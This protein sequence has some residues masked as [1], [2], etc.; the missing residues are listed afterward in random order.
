M[1]KITA[2]SLAAVLCCS[3]VACVCSDSSAESLGTTYITLAGDSIQMDGTGATVDGSTV[4]ITSAGTYSIS[5]TLNDGQIRVD[6]D[7]QEKVSLILN[8]A[9]IHCSSSAPIYVI[10]ADKTVIDLAEGTSNSISDGSSY[11]FTEAESDEPN[12]AIFSKDDLT[13]KGDGSLSV[14]ANYNDGITSK[15]DLKISGGSITVNAVNDGI[16]GKDSVEVKGGYITVTAGDD[17]IQSNNDEDAEKGIVSIEDGTIYIVA[18]GNGIQAETTLSISGGDIS[19][20]SGGGSSGT[21][22]LN[23]RD[24]RGMQTTT[25]TSDTDSAKGLKAGVQLTIT[26][27]TIDIDSSDDAVHSNDGIAI[28]GGD[29][30]LASGDDA[31]HADSALEINGGEIMI[32]R[33]YEGLESAAIT[34]NAGEIHLVASDD[35]VNGVTDGESSDMMMGRPG[36]NNFGASG[37]STLAINGGYLVID[38]GGDGLDI[39]GPITMTGGTVIINGPTNS[40]NGPLDYTGSYSI[41]GGTLIAAGSSGMAMAPSSSSLQCSAMLVYSASQTAG[42]IIHIE[43]ADGD[44]I[45]TF[46]PSK[47]YQSVV[48]SSPELTLGSDYVV[49]SGGSTT[50]TAK[51][52]LYS[53]GT[54]TPGT[55]VTNFE[56]SGTVTTVG[57]SNGQMPGNMPGNMAGNRTDYMPGSTSGGFA[58][59]SASSRLNEFLADSGIMNDYMQ[60]Y[61]TGVMNGNMPGSGAMNNN[62]GYGSDVM[63]SYRP[64]SGRMNNYVPGS[65]SSIGTQGITS[66]MIS[67]SLANVISGNFRR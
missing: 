43:T 14:D 21:T 56:I 44:E 50:G 26:G 55:E 46:K 45:L 10:N 38:A 49:Y 8:G 37:S 5:G 47:T 58:T 16:R 51:D 40:G 23:S 63:N 59:G 4:T 2:L 41:N 24:N 18:G 33:C 20:T 61:E 30:A 60:D 36:Q 11:V 32:T 17:G 48:F 39:N 12:A 53:G 28:N 19:V 15:D 22:Y 34:I 35:G 13:I 67:N 1:K 6:T 54:Y 31:I 9:F 65:G 57:S 25:P 7:D 52:G 29:L 27:G 3:L 64:G 66:N 62:P 42:T